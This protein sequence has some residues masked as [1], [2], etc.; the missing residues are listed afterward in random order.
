MDERLDEILTAYEDLWRGAALENRGQL[1]VS[2]AAKGAWG[3]CAALLP[4]Y[5]GREQLVADA[6]QQLDW[7]CPEDGTSACFLGG[8]MIHMNNI[9]KW[10][11]DRLANKFR[12]A[13]A[14]GMTP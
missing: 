10:P 12:D 1:N 4:H 9:H 14:E 13:L 8:V 2:V 7:T 6:M 3:G 11:W 5:V